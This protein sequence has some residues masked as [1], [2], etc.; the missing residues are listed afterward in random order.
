MCRVC[1]GVK[2]PD[3]KTALKTLISFLDAGIILERRKKGLDQVFRIV[4][5]YAPYS[6]KS[7]SGTI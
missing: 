7:T 5:M 1:L 3:G 4:N 2:C 6:D